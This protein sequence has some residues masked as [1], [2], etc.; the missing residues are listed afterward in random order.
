MKRWKECRT[1]FL[2]VKTKKKLAAATTTP[3]NVSYFVEPTW[4]W[5]NDYLPFCDTR[6]RYSKNSTDVSNHFFWIYQTWPF[7]G[8]VVDVVVVPLAVL[9][10]CCCCCFSS[11]FVVVL[12][13]ILF[14]THLIFILGLFTFLLLHNKDLLVEFNKFL[15]KMSAFPNNVM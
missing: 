10:Y 12:L 14:W 4:D 15:P 6:W 13:L 2:S 9:L 3:N 1:K 7:T 8:A 5:A 11:G